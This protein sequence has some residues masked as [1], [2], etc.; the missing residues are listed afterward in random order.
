M[1]GT[2]YAGSSSKYRQTILE[3]VFFYPIR[4]RGF[5][6]LS[7]S[8]VT[9]CHRKECF[10]LFHSTLLE[11]DRASR[12]RS[13]FKKLARTFRLYAFCHF[14]DFCILGWSGPEP[15]A[16]RQL[17]H[18]HSELAE[19]VAVFSPLRIRPSSLGRWSRYREAQLGKFC[20]G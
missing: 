7:T 3:R 20:L 8:T 9:S 13:V 12:G 11:G 1:N 14:H 19:A 2:W 6:V 5:R 10:S 16:L 4:Q 17:S 15:L 18:A